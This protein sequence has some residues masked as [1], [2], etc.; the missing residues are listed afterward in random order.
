MT[1]ALIASVSIA[2]I[3]P[4]YPELPNFHTVNKQ[5]YRGG[6]PKPGGVKKLA[7]AKLKQLEQFKSDATVGWDA[8]PITL[9]RLCAELYSQIHRDD[10][11]LVA[12]GI[13]NEWPLRL[14]NFD[15]THRWNGA[16][17][18]GGVGYN[19]PRSPT[20]NTDVSP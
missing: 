7:A 8:S 12:N 5:L 2:Q 3:D 6:Q 13:R 17:G 9:G 10:W 14:W 4:K 18:G 16:S 1:L 15:K 20:R 19:A 11:S